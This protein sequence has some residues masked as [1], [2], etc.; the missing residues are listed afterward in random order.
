[1]GTPSRCV[2]VMMGQKNR[3]CHQSTQNINQKRFS[4][5]NALVKNCFLFVR[6]KTNNAL[7]LSKQAMT[8]GPT[9]NALDGFY[10]YV[11]LLI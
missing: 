3:R 2:F 9:N 11:I 1:M 6:V 5:N 7:E 8:S 4:E 10:F